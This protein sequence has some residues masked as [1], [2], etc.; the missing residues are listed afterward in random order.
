[1]F[2]NRVVMLGSVLLVIAAV[3]THAVPIFFEHRGQGSGTING[4]PFVNADFLI[5]ASADTANRQAP[6]PIVFFINHDAASI[7]IDGVGTFAFITATRTFVNNDVSTVGFSRT[8]GPDLFNGPFDASFAT[9]DMLSA[10]GPHSGSGLLTQWGAGF[11]AVVTSGGVLEF[12]GQSNVR[13]TFQASLTPIIA[14]P[15]PA[16][17]TLGLFGIAGLL[18][19]RRRAA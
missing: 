7:T 3:E 10:I 11:G 19:R 4:N 16:T 15:E 18:I 6:N 14:A 12:N 2:S 13:T 17:A 9:W 8:S 1:M 5:S